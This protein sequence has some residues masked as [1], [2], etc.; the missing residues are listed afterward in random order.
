MKIFVLEDDS[1]YSD[2]IEYHLLLNEE[3]EVEKFSNAKDFFDNFYK[4]PDLVTL[5]YGL[6]DMA[7]ATVLKKI[8]ELDKN[9][10]IIVISGQEDI[11][12][13]VNLL[14]EGAFDY[15][16]KDDQMK[17]RLWL[18]M[19]HVKKNKKLLDENI[20]LKEEVEKKYSFEG[21]LKGRS[22]QIK[23]LFSIMNRAID[24]NITVSISGET[25]TG[26]ELVAK[27][28]H[29]NSPRKKQAFVAI[30]VGAVPSELLESE[31]FGHEKGSFTGANNRR[32]GRFEEAHKGSLFLDEIADMDASM[33]TKLLRVLQE[34]EIFRIGSNKA[35]KI[36]VRIITATHKN[37]L[38]EVKVA[39]FRQ[40]LYFRLLGLPIQISPL[41]ERDQDIIILSKFFADEFCKENKRT[42]LKFTAEAKRKLLNYPFTGNV[43]ELKAVVELAVIMSDYDEITEDAISFNAS[44]SVS[45]ILLKEKTLDAYTVDIIQYF[46]AKYNKDAILVAEKLGVAKSTIYRYIKKHNL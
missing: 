33:Q 8:Q 16:V 19:L 4:K 2:I 41:R 28:I 42:K 45:D 10:P 34:K 22:P 29:Y 3:N 26:K 38:E 46:L 5:D 1:W 7:G 9:L 32:I 35:I 40:D 12:T 11:S 14:S 21:I 24:N 18:S 17:D 37:L 6:P 44:D 23:Q 13:A 43:R 15:I 31:L 27:A 20:Q 25:G 36:D 30:N 39:N